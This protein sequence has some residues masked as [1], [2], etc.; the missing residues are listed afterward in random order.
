MLVVFE[1]ILYWKVD[2]MWEWDDPMYCYFVGYG[3]V[4]VR[5]DF[6]G[7]GDLG[8]VLVDEYDV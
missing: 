7:I 8:G 2:G 5:V 1:Y 4:V 6:C 3:Y